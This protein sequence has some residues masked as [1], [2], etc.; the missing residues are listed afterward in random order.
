[1][2]L[3]VVILGPAGTG[4]SLLLRGL[5]PSTDNPEQDHS[6]TYYSTIG[7]DSRFLRHEDVTV[8]LDDIS[9]NDRFSGLRKSFIA[10]SNH[11]IIV[12]SAHSKTLNAD[13]EKCLAE[14][15]D[16][17][18]SVDAHKVLLIINEAK[19]S[20]DLLEK[21]FSISDP[22]LK[23]IP[24]ITVGQIFPDSNNLFICNIRKMIMHRFANAK[25]YNGQV[26]HITGNNTASSASS[27]TFFSTLRNYFSG[28]NTKSD[29]KSTPS[30]P[31]LQNRH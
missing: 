23:K 22:A 3:N 8:R 29:I 17:K 27:L 24:Y 5:S 19:E 2:R 30:E 6:I 15:D 9:G 11:F 16:V 28:S 31:L 13:I 7:V 1:M 4:K 18:K 10:Q 14:I 25:N 21:V 26:T 20:K 12:I